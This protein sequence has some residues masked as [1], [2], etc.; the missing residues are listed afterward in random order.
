MVTAQSFHLNYGNCILP[1]MKRTVST[2]QHP[3]DRLLG[4]EDDGS[5]SLLEFVAQEYAGE[6][7]EADKFARELTAKLG[8]MRYPQ[9]DPIE[10]KPFFSEI[11]ERAAVLSELLSADTLRELWKSLVLKKV[12]ERYRELRDRKQSVHGISLEEHWRKVREARRDMRIYKKLDDKYHFDYTLSA[13][14]KMA[15]GSVR[16]MVA[17]WMSRFIGPRATLLSIHLPV[18]K[19][20]SKLQTGRKRT[21]KPAATEPSAGP[22]NEDKRIQA[23]IY[24]TLERRLQTP[25]TYR[26]G[27]DDIFLCQLAELIWS[28]A[29]VQRLS[30]G[31]SL[32]RDINRWRR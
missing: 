32:R 13:Y 9:P 17:I 16:E 8:R 31:E 24:A 22:R 25:E 10:S 2:Y 3:L 23:H 14:E 15:R 29:D 20:K 26:T 21:P 27:I 4:D 28:G 6:G 12:F 5:P 19:W 11:L 18:Q 1:T 30:D 7:F